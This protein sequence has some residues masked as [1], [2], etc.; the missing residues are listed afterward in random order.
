MILLYGASPWPAFRQAEWAE[1]IADSAALYLIDAPADTDPAIVARLCQVLDAQPW[2]APSDGSNA[3]DHSHWLILPRPDTRTPWASRAGDIVRRCGLPELATLEMAV[4]LRCKPGVDLSQDAAMAASLHDRMTQVLW[5]LGTDLSTWFEPPEPAPLQHIVLGDQP[6]QALAEANQT[7]G[8]ALSADEVDYLAEAFSAMG[9]D[10]SDAEL[11]M[12]AQANSEHCRHK[13]FNASWTLDGQP[14][15]HSLF[16]LIR[17]THAA[18]PGGIEVAYS[19]NAAILTGREVELLSAQAEGAVLDSRYVPSPTTLHVQIKV[20]THNHPTAISPDPGAATGAGGEIRDEA[21][22]GRGGRPVAGLTGFSVSDLCLP[23]HP[24]P[25]E[26]SP[27]PPGRMA[28]A[29]RIMIEGPI[30]AARFNNEFGRPAVLGYFRSFAQQVGGRHWGYHKPI[31]LAGG[32]GQLHA[33][34]THKLPLSPGDRIIVL[35]GPAMLIGL[36]GGAASSVAA[37][38]SDEALDFASVQRG[39]P[40]MQ[41]RCQEVIDRCWTR[42]VDNPIKSIHDVGAGGLSNAIPELLHDGGV[43]GHLSLRA[44]PSADPGLSPMAIWCNEAQERYVLAVTPE[45]VPSLQALCERERCPMAD[46]GQA[47]GDG[48]LLLI[49]DDNG[50]AVIDLDLNVL[51]GKPPSV[52]RD[53]MTVATACVDEGLAGLSFDAAVDRVLALPGVGSKS[54]L[55]TIGDRSVGGLTVRDQMVGPHQVPVADNAICAL[56]YVGHA[57]TVMSMGERTPLAVWDAA[58]AA[59]LAIAETLTNMA[60]V[61]VGAIDRVSLSANWMAAAGTPGQDAAL[62]AAVTASSDLCQQLGL[63]IP[64][65]KDSLSMHTQWRDAE[66]EQAQSA[67]VS[68]I[69]SGFAVLSDVRAHCTPQLQAEP[70]R[71][72]LIDL[73]QGRSRLGGSAL[74]QVFVREL[75]AVPDLE[76]AAALQHAFAVI[77]GLLADG[78]LLACHDRSEGGLM[79]TLLEMALAGHCGLAIHA[80]DLELARW[81][82]EE[83]GWV[84]QVPAGAVDQVMARFAAADLAECV[85]DMG[86][87][88]AFD[89]ADA[90]FTLTTASGQS[91]SRP[92]AD[93]A[94]AWSAVSHQMARLR[95]DPDCADQAMA[96]LSDWS[97]PGLCPR[98][99]FE[100]SPPPVVLTGA[101]PQVAILREQGINGQREMAQAFIAAG[102]EAVDVHMSDL[103]AGRH[104]LKHFQGVVACGGFSFGDVLGAGQGWARSI[105]HQPD[106]AEAFAEFFADPGRFALGVCNGCQM[107]SALRTL[108]PGTQRWPDFVHNQSWQFEA[109]LSQVRIEPSPSLFFADM[110]GSVIPVVTAH[111]EGRAQ[112][113]TEGLDERQVALRYVDGHGQPTQ[114]YPDNPNGSPQ[115]VTGLCND[116]GR[117]TILMPHPERLLRTL[118][119]SWAPPSW[120]P[121]SPWQRMFH[122]A[123]QWV[124]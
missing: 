5:P 90:A 72:M 101:K 98:I 53:A 3:Q 122:N 23:N 78:L 12:F 76:D 115:G 85:T 77:Q 51:L 39:N 74:A 48:R 110:V 111:G 105:L 58:A 70:A 18:S 83:L 67:P 14:L 38:Q 93:L 84:I 35:G 52:H 1:H 100:V 56:D 63:A 119:F 60:S 2:A 121:E 114:D 82:N 59:R 45:S 42:G 112:P 117:I 65:G 87:A 49:D 80:P 28:T 30:G 4:L 46:V 33:E 104:Q 32:S 11:M 103:R 96:A 61:Q 15:A 88:V 7:M 81:F 107:F 109:R 75:G 62:R 9:R 89:Q 64:V 27:P 16:D 19:D 91:W 69:V 17:H 106:L 31:M 43:G 40:E 124:A 66:G 50:Q 37:G 22:T 57:G 8:L 123:R 55:I 41:R 108:M 73:S 10:P 24:Q 118:N 29:C 6:Q 86:E 92:M 47:T 25:W 36:G 94:S 102:F 21:A 20:E 99:G 44:I 34:H 97:R 116:D 13:I 113:G 71:L 95:D 54:F 120:G 79:V 26:R 68:L